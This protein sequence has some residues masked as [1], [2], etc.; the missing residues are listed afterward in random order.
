MCDTLAASGALT[1]HGRI[2][3]AKNS[4]RKAGECQPFV[5]HPAASHPR[6]S[7]VRCTH[8]EVP[9]VAETYRVMGHSPWWCWGFEHGANEHAVAIG[10]LAVFSR[11]P[12]EETPGLIGM[13]LVRLGLERGRTA[14]E[15]L[16][17]IAAL[18]E[19]HGQ[20]GPALAPDGPGYHNAFHLAD[21]EESWILETS[22]RRWAARRAELGACSNHLG[23]GRDWE[24]ASRDLES[25]ARAAGFWSEE[26]RIDVAAAYRNPDVPEH[27]SSG[28]RR[29]ARELLESA[30]GELDVS[31][32]QAA[33]RDHGPMGETWRPEPSPQE[34]AY[35]TI[36]A[37][38]DPVSWTTAS[39]VAE[40]PK[41][42]AAPWPVWI[43]FATP[44]TSVFLPVYQE[45]LVPPALARDGVHPTSDSAWWVFK[46]LQDAVSKDPV[47]LA[48]EVRRGWKELES[49]AEAERIRTEAE[50]L[51][52]HH[53]H[54]RARLLT[55]LMARIWEAALARAE[56][57][58]A[59][60]EAAS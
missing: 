6:G 53:P 19:T 40:L 48:P 36:C 60:V 31:H 4:D 32:L 25:F 26:G 33:L 5:Q 17:I 50:A 45:G 35:F 22:N 47:R 55:E 56:E 11:E 49:W 10:N 37:H 24:I 38:S 51:R 7:R 21:P 20:G 39:L 41:D 30:R 23:L 8:V 59:E 44:C 14:R 57:L 16:E 9:Q 13:D 15:A 27:I 43:S 29:R 3:F 58:R 54:E 52:A 2:L 34:E 1:A 18:L 28:R 12:V 42:R 46:A